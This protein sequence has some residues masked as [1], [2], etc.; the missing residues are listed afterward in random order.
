MK[1]KVCDE[2]FK[3]DRMDYPKLLPMV[4]KQAVFKAIGRVLREW[5]KE[6]KYEG[7]DLN[8][9]DVANER[10]AIGRFLTKELRKEVR[11]L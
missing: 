9:N 5:V 7:Q 6:N 11:G 1:C 3:K 4:S 2:H 8:W 10:I